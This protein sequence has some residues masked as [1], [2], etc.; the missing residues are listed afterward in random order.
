M[1]RLLEFF[2]ITASAEAEQ[3]Y[4]DIV[5]ARLNCY[6]EGQRAAQAGAEFW[7][8]PHSSPDSSRESWTRWN[9]G[10]CYGK[11]LARDGK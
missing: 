2:G 3:A 8:N 4:R 7:E 10:W 6:G 5:A 1:K 11:Q 9:A